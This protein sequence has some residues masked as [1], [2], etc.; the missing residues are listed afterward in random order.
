MGKSKR[1]P[2]GRAIKLLEWY[3]RSR[4][5]LPW[6]APPGRK[7]DPYAVWLSEIMLQQ[8]TV[9]AVAAYYRKFLALWP[10]VKKLAAAPVEEVMQAWAGLGYYSRA[11]NLH[12]CAKKIVSDHGGRFPSDEAGLRALP[13]VGPYTA[14]AIAAIAFGRRA[15]VVDG[16]IKRV[17]ARLLSLETPLPA[18]E[19]PIGAF[20]DSLTPEKR[21]GDFAQGLMDLGATVC[22][23]RNPACPECPLRDDCTAGED[24]NPEDYPRKP[25]KKPRPQRRGAAFYLRR[26]DGAVLTRTRPPRGLLGGMVEVPGSDWRADR[27]ADW[28]LRHAERSAPVSGVPWRHAGDVD[29]VFTHF[30]LNLTVFVGAAPVGTIPPEGCF[31]LDAT[32][33]RQAALPSVMRKVEARAQSCLQSS[34]VRSNGGRLEIP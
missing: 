29:H 2:D 21:A 6:R 13:G 11:R 12:A 33:M 31:W 26:A 23:P 3:D 16:N 30:S 1:E 4:R 22:T 24:R 5:D 10:D 18:G 14:A 8:T 15:V 27:G 32:Q 25:R 28:A 17:A 34:L 20:I 19:K 7:P 9:A